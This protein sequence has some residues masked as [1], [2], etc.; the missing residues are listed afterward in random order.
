MN[1]ETL[2]WVLIWGAAGTCAVWFLS[3]FLFRVAGEW[4]RLLPDTATRT[5]GDEERF[6]LSQFG[7]FVSGRC[8][9][10]GGHQTLSG[11]IIGRTL[12]LRRRDHGH[13]HLEKQGFPPEVARRL[14]GQIFARFELRLRNQGLLLD[15]SIY[16]RRIEFTHQPPRVTGIF[17]AP[18]A[19]RTYSRVTPL[20]A[21][22]P[23]EPWTDEVSA[24]STH[25]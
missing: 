1:G 8:S 5:P 22:E 9:V 12:Y 4:I 25:P 16:P 23:V 15:G 3:A 14:D 7:P 10:P 17:Q 13:R 21:A 24:P 19:P 6:Q 11:L 2:R 18:S 20:S